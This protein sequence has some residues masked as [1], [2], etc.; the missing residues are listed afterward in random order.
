M[1]QLTIRDVANLSGIKA[2]TLRTW[3]QRYGLFVC[4]RKLSQHRYYENEDLKFILR[5]AYLYHRGFRISDIAGL[6]PELINTIIENRLN[7]NELDSRVHKLLESSIGFDEKQFDEVLTETETSLGI[8]KAMQIVIN[9][10]LEKMQMLWITERVL[11]TQQR[12]CHHLIQ[13]KLI[14]AI[15]ALPTIEKKGQPCILFF[16]PPGEND[17][18]GLLAAQYAFKRKGYAT[19]LLGCAVKLDTIA[20]CCLHLPVTHLFLH[21]GVASQKH[22]TLQYLKQLKRLAHGQQIMVG[23]Q[24]A[25]DTESLPDGII[26]SDK[27]EALVDAVG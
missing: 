26:L 25:C 6:S 27:L 15:N 24:R 3:E 18:L 2:H 9:P 13:K 21:F 11:P 7:N 4:K 16:N 23:G 8:E 12:F 22:S 17:E 20:Y 19:I 5:I 10:F 14:A 1:H